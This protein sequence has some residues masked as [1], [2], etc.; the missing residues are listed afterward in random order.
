MFQN[1]ISRSPG[2]KICGLQIKIT[3]E[4]TYSPGLQTSNDVPEVFGRKKND[5]TV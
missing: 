3:V 1:S 5:E 2:A 4:D